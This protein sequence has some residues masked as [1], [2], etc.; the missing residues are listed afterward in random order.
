MT[1]HTHCH[2]LAGLHRKSAA[3]EKQPG[4]GRGRGQGKKGDSGWVVPSLAGATGRGKGKAL[5]K[6]TPIIKTCMLN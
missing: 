2:T 1:I 3:E 4:T 5:Q 6:G